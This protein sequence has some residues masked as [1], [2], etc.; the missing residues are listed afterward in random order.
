VSLISVA[1]IAV[2]G[3]TDPRVGVAMR[4]PVTTTSV[5]AGAVS[6]WS[7]VDAGGVCATDVCVARAAA[8]VPL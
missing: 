5:I 1:E 7:L 2:M 6:G 8:T 3:L 4:E